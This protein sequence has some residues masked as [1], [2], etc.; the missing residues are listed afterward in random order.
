VLRRLRLVGVVVLAAGVWSAAGAAASGAQ[1]VGCVAGEDRWTPLERWVWVELCTGGSAEANRAGE[2]GFGDDYDADAAA[3]RAD[4]V[5][6]S[7]V[8]KVMLRESPYRELLVGRPLRLSDFEVRGELDLS[9]AA[10]DGSLTVS[11]VRF[12]SAVRLVGAH[13]GAVLADARFDQG[14][15]LTSATIEG[16]LSLAG[17]Q[18]GYLSAAGLTTSAGLDLSGARVEG[19]V[20]LFGASIGGFLNLGNSAHFHDV[21]MSSSQVGG[22]LTVND[23]TVINE[24][25]MTDASVDGSL[26]VREGTSVDRLSANATRVGTNVEIQSASVHVVNLDGAN[27]DGSVFIRSDAEI[28]KANLFG[29]DIGGDLQLF[30]ARFDEL[31]DLRGSRIEGDLSLSNGDAIT[32]WG[33]GALMDLRGAEV[34]SISDAADAWAPSLRLQGF[35][36]ASMDGPLSREDGFGS[37]DNHWYI[38]WLQRQESFA[39]QPYT[40]L[41]AMLR[42]AGR[43]GFANDVG[44]AR[45]AAEQRQQLSPLSVVGWSHRLLS[46]YGYEPLRAA[47]WAVGLT[48]LGALILRVFVSKQRRTAAGMRNV[49]IYS[50][51]RLIP[52]V[53]LERDDKEVDLRSAV[54]GKRW[55][56]WYFYVHSAIGYVL[57]ALLIVALGQ[58]SFG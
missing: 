24:L 29:S 47:F 42:A 38:K 34:A 13:L 40:Q 17:S 36:Y 20:D 22:N 45:Y 19:D 35:V 28:V 5:V 7:D 9:G 43:S 3:P 21:F 1:A 11:N 57:A 48:V 6:R 26:L 16:V 12:T 33:E 58:L 54:G 10:R 32:R 49:V 15:D 4:R 14:L 46:G 52:V 18:L 30:G 55:I 50:L 2:A 39:G 8:L 53:T 31:V 56:C 37:R 25:R 51:D 27:V 44:F 23:S 41:E